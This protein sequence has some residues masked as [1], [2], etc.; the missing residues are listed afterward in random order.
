MIFRRLAA[1]SLA[2]PLALALAACGSS[3]EDAATGEVPQ[4]EPVAAVPAPEGQDW[5]SVTE[6]TEQQGHRIGNPDAPI[7][8]VEYGS[9]TCGACA[10]FTQTGFED[11]RENYVNT[12]RVSFELRPLILNGL[13]LVMVRLARCSTDE[14][15]VPLSEQVWQNFDSVMTSAQQGGEQ[16]QQ[17]MNLPEDQRFFAIAQSANLLDFFA[18][19]GVSRDQAQTCLADADSVT[20]IADRSQ[21]QAAEFDVS[22]TPTFFL[23]GRKLDVNTWDALEPVLQRA[24]AR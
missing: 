16:F 2:A 12:G 1:A 11:L 8:L 23:N 20:A 3:E 14:A 22:G 10:N 21:A 17:A 18:A 5:A 15:V 7:K 4:G 9:L 6:V 13:D 19:R 24:G